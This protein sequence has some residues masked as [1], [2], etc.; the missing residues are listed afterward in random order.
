MVRLKE[1]DCAWHFSAY[2][3]ALLYSV[4]W[5]AITIQ[6]VRKAAK[7]DVHDFRACNG[8]TDCYYYRLFPEPL[9]PTSAD[10]FF[11]QNGVTLPDDING[12]KVVVL[13]E[14][15]PNLMCRATQEETAQFCNSKEMVNNIDTGMSQEAKIVLIVTMFV[16]ASCDFFHD[17]FLMNRHYI[18][19]A[20]FA[21]LS[22]LALLVMVP[23][24]FAFCS[25]LAEVFVSESNDKGCVCYYRPD[26][27]AVV[28][29]IAVPLS[30]M[31][32]FK[33]RTLNLIKAL[34]FGDYLFFWAQNIPFRLLKHNVRGESISAY[35]DTLL[36]ANIYGDIKN[37]KVDD[38]DRRIPFR[39]MVPTFPSV[40]ELRDEYF[41]EGCALSKVLFVLI[42]SIPSICM[43]AFY[44]RFAI[45][46]LYDHH[47]GGFTACF[48]IMSMIIAQICMIV[49]WG[50]CQTPESVWSLAILYLSFYNF[51]S[52]AFLS[53]P[54]TNKAIFVLTDFIGYH[55]N[56]KNM[57]HGFP[58]LPI[59]TAAFY[60]FWC[61]TVV[62]YQSFVT[63]G[64]MQTNEDGKYLTRPAVQ[65]GSCMPSFDYA[66]ASDSD[67]DVRS[68]DV[69]DESD[70][71]EEHP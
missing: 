67:T 36:V 38:E 53:R 48:L 70:Y 71:E 27:V 26:L 49:V 59:V 58:L 42:F 62:C 51:A 15:F 34:T 61:Y 32:H 3:E 25:G 11:V 30:L 31:L 37:A 63:S 20:A 65:S 29:T 46:K 2:K 47:W 39:K 4:L 41:G 64:Q 60:A 28:L 40:S 50:A 1:V 5:G 7:L 54:I 44:T 66:S 10:F 22:W 16:K 56:A 43:M 13:G 33:N 12:T 19:S 69:E 68:E 9:M 6:F 18:T 55:E 52:S 57:P 21:I 45:L 8:P 23:F 14:H 17:V 35:D 24:A